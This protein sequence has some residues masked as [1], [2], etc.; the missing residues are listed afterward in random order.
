MESGQG[1]AELYWLADARRW[2]EDR[3]RQVADV[4][5]RRIRRGG[6]PGGVL[7]G[8][9]SL[10]SEFGAPRKAIRDA[11]SIL[12]EEGLVDR[13]Q[14]AGISAT[15]REYPHGLHPLQDLAGTLR[16]HGEIVNEV[17]AAGMI[18][19]PPPIATRLATSGRV[20][21]IERLRWLNGLPLS[22]DLTY[23]ARDIG[24]P[25]LDEDLEHNDIIALIGSRAGQGIG[26]AS[27]AVE[28]VTADPQSAA[29][30][31]VPPGAAVLMAE[32]LTYL[33]D[34]RP[35]DLDYIRIRGDRLVLR[36]ELGRIGADHAPR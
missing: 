16:E 10:A 6:L 22:L 21:Y 12:R 27:V 34:G 14:G 18:V 33:A 32:R 11:L 1:A 9:A 28:A 24:E 17:R 7:P 23:L 31:E 25:L 5:R 29:A 26:G 8:E 15:D 20:V 35:V 30:L 3:A 19:P 2:R 4:L 36:G 13:R